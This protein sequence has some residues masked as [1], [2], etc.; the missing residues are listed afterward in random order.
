MINAQEL[1]FWSL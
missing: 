1:S